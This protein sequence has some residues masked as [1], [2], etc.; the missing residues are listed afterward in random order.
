M[1]TLGSLFDGSGTFPVAGMLS[2][3]KPVWAS[4]IEPF[5]IAV[6]RTRLP[7]MKHYG[8]VSK[9]NGAEIEPVDIITFGSPC[10]DMSVAGKR[11]GLEGSRS[12]LFHQAIR[13]IKEM[14]CAT[15]GKYPRFAVWENVCF[16]AGTLVTTEY[17]Y[18]PI[19]TIQVGDKVKTLSGKYMPVRK[20]YK[21]RKKEVIQIKA[22][23]SESLVCT[24]NHPFYV[25]KRFI[26]SDDLSYRESFSKAEWR[27]AGELTTDD[28][29]GYVLDT[30]DERFSDFVT[31]AEAWAIGRWLADG[32]VDLKKSNP[33]IF[34][35]CGE[36]K[37]EAT[38]ERLHRLPYDIYENRPHSTALNFTFTS[39]E[40]YKLIESA[41][42]GAE[43]KCVPPY[44]FKLPIHLQKA[45]LEGYISG[46]GYIRRRKYHTELSAST[47][48]RELAYGISR[49]IRNCYHEGCS[50]SVTPPKD[51]VINGRIIHANHPVYM[52]TACLY[53]KQS[54][55]FVEN[56]ILWQPIK[57]IEKIDKKENV[58]NL[59]VEDDNTYEVN[60]IIV[61]NCGAYSS[62]N[63]EDFRCVLE[64][65]CKVKGEDVSVPKPKKWEKAGSIVADD[66]SVAWRTFDSQ[67]WGIPQRRVRIYLVA[68]F[69]GQCAEKIL[70][71]SEGLSGYSTEGF[72][73]WQ[74]SAGGAADCI[75]ATGTGVMFSNHSHDTRF[76]GPI[77]V[78][79]TVSA[80]YGT[81]G[82][83]QPF[84]VES[85]GFCT[86]HSAKA[87][88]IGYEKEK[89]PTL[90]AGVV[91]AA[92]I[93]PKA[94]GVCSKHSNSMLS[95]NPNS[96]F[97]EAD[98]A[99][100][101]DT[102]NQ[103]PCKNQGGMIV[104]EGNGS[105]PSHHGDG[106]KE[107]ETMYT[108]NCTENHAVAFG[109]GRP[110]MN[111]GYNARFSFQI[112]E[113]TSPTLV[114]SGAGGVAHPT[115]CASKASY[116]TRADEEKAGALVATDYK[117]PPLINDTADGVE[118]IVRRLTPQECALLQGMPTWWCDGLGIENPTEEDIAFW[119]DVF[120]THR[121]AFSPDTKPKTDRQILKWI[122]NPYSDSAAY[123]MWG[124][125]ISLP[126]GWF[127]LAGI[128]YYAQNNGE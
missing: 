46:D 98:T 38:R 89:A 64:E 76:T 13:I 65:F 90:R 100:T 91:P 43:N 35:S 39:W 117:D 26:H 32:S 10:Q 52:L 9:I 96:G 21:T 110:A 121:L 77:D 78:A 124:N 105:R 61:H 128:A 5:P 33:R 88:G 60:N 79:D 119:R 8:D 3:I 51:G 54:K 1:L 16:T 22:T 49:L 118:Y 58:Y 97:Y 11:V 20:I 57:S 99:K 62:N 41:R 59:S 123:K 17:G 71:E 29:I 95:D 84:V 4:E 63:G 115:Y 82:N 56:G 116:F 53:T 92:M 72:R 2:G 40:F 80:I 15:N 18:K 122:K 45:V 111:Q 7:F 101:I 106:Y 36:K 55:S 69:T 25:K 31:E 75:G 66:Y 6:T 126:V 34:I 14:R 28:L 81:G 109:I 48:S 68:D 24:P 47:V 83:N 114:A 70:F 74:S 23:G 85:A 125:S 19:E 50:I 27:R 93:V 44:V 86:E 42:K 103:S 37:I 73:A 87:R 102:S 12:S 104:I 94:Y 30:P 127:V 112:E 120:E 108:L 67:H 107:S 113:E